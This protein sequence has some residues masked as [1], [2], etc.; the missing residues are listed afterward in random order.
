MDYRPPYSCAS[1]ANSFVDCAINHSC[2]RCSRLSVDRYR[3][4]YRE[5]VHRDE[6][7][8]LFEFNLIAG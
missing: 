4:V 3:V 7:K 1:M 6:A 5:H 8:D 2:F